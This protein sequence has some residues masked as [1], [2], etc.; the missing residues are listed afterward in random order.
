MTTVKKPG[1]SF[2]A[3]F[4]V[5][6]AG[7]LCLAVPSGSGWINL[8]VAPV[9]LLIGYIVL[10]PLG[11]WPGG[12]DEFPGFRSSCR[13]RLPASVK[14]VGL[15]VF[16]VTISVYLATLWP[17]PGWWDSG[18]YITCCYTLGVTGPPGSVLLQLLGRMASFIGLVSS[19]AVRING[20]VALLG[21]ASASLFYFL[22]YR[23]IQSLYSERIHFLL[24]AAAAAM[25]A[26]TLAFTE[27]VWREATFTNPYML[28]MLMG[29]LLVYL[30]VRWWENPESS[31]SGNFL[32]LAAFFSGIDMSVHRS[33][34]VLIPAFMVMILIRRPRTFLDIK[35]LFSAMALLFIGMSMQLIVMFRAQQNPQINMGNPIT[36][37]GLWNY[38]TLSQYG[39]ATFGSDLLA[40]KAPFWTY[41]IR[42]MYLRYFG[43]NFIGMDNLG[44][45][46]SWTGLYGIPAVIG[47]AGLLI[48]FIKRRSQAIC[49]LLF[50]LMASLGAV[51]YLNVPLNFFRDMDRHFLV[52]FMLF[53]IWIGIACYFLIVS[54]GR[55]LG[56][57]FGLDSIF[58][59]AAAGILFAVLPINEFIANRQNNNMSANYMAYAFGSN[60]LKSCE[61][62]A[63]LITAGDS[64]TFLP[65]YL[66]MVERIRPDIT[67]LNINL[68]NTDWYLR[69]VMSY[70]P[71]FPW[72]LTVDAIASL[73][74]IS[75]EKD[76]AFLPGTDNSADSFSVPVKAALV[77]QNAFMLVQDQVLLDIIKENKWKRP[78]CFS[79]GFGERLPVYIKADCRLDGLAWRVVPDSGEFGGYRALEEN[80]LDRFDFRGLGKRTFL[81]RTGE[82]ITRMYRPAFARLY[83]V[84]DSLGDREKAARL[85]ERFEELW[86]QSD[87]LVPGGGQ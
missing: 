5:L 11:L 62:D 1:V 4:G 39:I 14:L 21:A 73:R 33:N 61:P 34:I 22:V 29:I 7:Y 70:Y 27:S 63:I 38:L 71:D 66:Q 80:L 43:W 16:T 17:G 76:S 30:A 79:C 46:T 10:L 59:Y 58:R 64:D 84:Y 74:P 31:D 40:R 49:L 23:I 69:T 86:P 13:G 87:G 15:S 65:W 42:E 45:A 68:L 57:A 12:R 83:Q 77:G 52:S 37:K 51:F 53:C 72:S 50:F 67:V 28:S 81:D 41:Q 78:V 36:L 47:L 54:V 85:S 55:L 44:N 19:P 20:L 32:L 9:L 25:A 48:H 75:W 35:L 82:G 6:V 2:Y 3:A 18:E 8:T 60:L 56:Y 24:G 26:L